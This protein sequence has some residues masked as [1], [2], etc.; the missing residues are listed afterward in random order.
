MGNSI[1]ADLRFAF[2]RANL[3]GTLVSLLLLAAFNLVWPVILHAFVGLTWPYLIIL[4]VAGFLVLAAL[5]L[6]FGQ[7]KQRKPQPA[8][9]TSNVGIVGPLVRNVQRQPGTRY[10]RLQGLYD[11][12]QHL[13]QQLQAE[14]SPLA[15]MMLLSQSAG[16]SVGVAKEIKN[17]AP[18]HYRKWTEIVAETDRTAKGLEQRL[19]RLDGIMVQLRAKDGG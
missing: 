8:I 6:R 13:L 11:K 2:S 9:D 1:R 7:G 16:W 18:E 15:L 3:F 10:E 12:G 17:I 19:E 14:P 5:L 4:G